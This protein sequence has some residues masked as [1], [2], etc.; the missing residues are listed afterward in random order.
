MKR[1]ALA[2]AAA[3]ALLAASPA[4]SAELF[5]TIDSINLGYKE[6]KVEIAR[7]TVQDSATLAVQ[8]NDVNVLMRSDGRDRVEI[9]ATTIGLGYHEQTVSITDNTL[10]GDAAVAVQQG[11]LGV[12]LN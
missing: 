10:S 2:A 6:Q 8:Q 11:V 7:N 4:S 12:I 3:A 9:D 5:A 1:T